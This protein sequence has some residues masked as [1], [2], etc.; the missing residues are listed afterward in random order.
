MHTALSRCAHASVV[1][2]EDDVCW[3]ASLDDVKLAVAQTQH[4]FVVVCLLAGAHAELDE[5]DFFHSTPRVTCRSKMTTNVKKEECGFRTESVRL[6]GMVHPT[7]RL[8][9]HAGVVVS[10]FSESLLPCKYKIRRSEKEQVSSQ[11]ADAE[12]QTTSDPSLQSLRSFPINGIRSNYGA[13]CKDD[14]HTSAKFYKTP[15]APTHPRAQPRS[16]LPSSKQPRSRS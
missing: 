1:R 9:A 12:R 5:D 14:V 8:C 10:C 2:K 16:P 13:S 3:A 11:S 7:W 4:G 15:T 6:W